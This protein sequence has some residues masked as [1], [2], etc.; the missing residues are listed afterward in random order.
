[1]QLETRPGDPYSVNIWGVGVGADFYI[2]AG[3][4]SGTWATSIAANPDVRLKIG[5][6]IFEMRAQRVEDDAEID[7]FLAALQRK[8][9]FEPDPGQRDEAAVYRLG[10]RS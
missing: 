2:G 3:D 1:M 10:P 6:A 8:Y 7:A 4:P 9:D 5:A